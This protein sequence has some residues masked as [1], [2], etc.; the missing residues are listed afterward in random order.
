MVQ[1]YEKNENYYPKKIFTKISQLITT[2]QT[3][4]YKFYFLQL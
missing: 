2:Y 3:K 1:K 4:H